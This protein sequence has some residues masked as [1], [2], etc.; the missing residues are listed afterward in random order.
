MYMYDTYYKHIVA[1]I[2]S[3]SSMLCVK[4]ICSLIYN[5]YGCNIILAYNFWVCLCFFAAA[6]AR[7]VYNYVFLAHTHTIDGACVRVSFRGKRLLLDLV[8]K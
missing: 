8:I 2:R 1:H 5:E 4:Y 3:V 7:F 6:V